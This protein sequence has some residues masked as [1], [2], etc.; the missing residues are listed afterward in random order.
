MR[1][2]LQLL[3]LISISSACLSQSAIVKGK[4][5]D[6][7]EK[8]TLSNAVISL[9]RQ[10]DSTLY[11]FSRSNSNGEFSIPNITPGKYRLLV[12]FPKFADYSDDLEVNKPV[13]DLGTIPL[14]GKAKLLEEVIVRG[15][16][17]IKIKGDTTEF[18]ADSFKVR[19]GATVEDLLKEFPGFQVDSK[20]QITVQGKQVGKVLV[21]GEEFFGDDP[22]MATQNISAKAVDKV[23]VFDTKT[24]QQ[25]LTG[26]S[27]GNE[28]KTVNIKL[29]ESAKK[30]AF[31][32][33]HAASDFD[34]YFDGKALYNNFVGKK[35]VSVYGT[36][37]NLNTGS[38]TYEDRN[39]LGMEEDLEYDEIN[40]Y[41]Y[42]FSN[43]DEFNDY[44]LR[45]LPEA[46]TAGGLFSNKWDYDKHNVNGSYRFNR[47]ATNNIN[48][49]RSQ[50]L[51]PGSSFYSNNLTKSRGLNQQHALNAKYEWKIDSLA[52][53]KFV[54]AGIYKTSDTYTDTYSESLDAKFDTIN[55]RSQTRD[56][57]TER[58]QMD[59]QLTYKQLFRKKNRQMIVTLRHGYTEDDQEG[60]LNAIIGRKNLPDS[61]V[62]Q[63]KL[64]NGNSTTVG[65]KITFSEPLSLK[66][67][68]VVDYSFNNNNSTSHLNSFNKNSNNDK[69]EA[70]DPVF[71]NNFDLGATSNS[72]NLTMRYMGTK[73]RFAFGSGLSSIN[74]RL[75]NL[76][77]GV[78][79]KYNFLNVTPQATFSYTFKAQTSV[80]FSY[81][82][83]TRQ[84][85]INQLQ[86]IRNNEDLMNI[87]VGNPNLKVGFNHSVNASFNSYKVL[88]S[89]YFYI[90]GY[91]SVTENAIATSSTIDTNLKRTY[92]PINVNGNNSWSTQIQ[93]SRGTGDKKFRHNAYTYVNGGRN[94][95]LI[96]G[97]KGYNNYTTYQANY[98]TSYNV[99]D[100]YN[101]Y[102]G[103]QISYNKSKSSLQ[104]SIDNNYFT[105]GG[106]AGGYVMLPGKIEVSSDVNMQLRERV[107]V[108]SQNTDIIMW[109]AN[110]S[111]K[112][113]KDKSGKIF[114]IAN[115]ILDQNKGWNRSI[116]G[117]TITD[118]RFLSV[119][120]YFLLKF[121]WTFN[122]MP[123]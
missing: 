30:G 59:N 82:G 89:R 70:F 33:V 71:S 76:D 55:T 97:N 17:A 12:S 16:Q 122:K 96:N 3:M 121:E 116:N 42:S 47:L 28:S 65:S 79:N 53:L 40:G 2:L 83:T 64:G 103:P 80:G 10:S 87:Y 32:K 18:N 78:K 92:T 57:S 48:S 114:I 119:S 39:K 91:Y 25:Q 84:P 13:I 123:K 34:R 38:L 73:A 54:T 19:D 72:G 99:T 31:G 46:Y 118:S 15:G 61:L 107:G 7:L 120:R 20:G 27:T 95:V 52:S 60:M 106:R 110:I 49:T 85:T 62:D 1:K 113:F 75:H 112:I 56:N 77:N 14:T 111:R 68:I 24:D 102:I 45:G 93:W 69:Y 98:N 5:S 21:D 90:S 86:P 101:F 108:L 117:E 26:I 23:Q 41:Y 6:T 29:K 9:T 94:V 11:K 109:N 36:K 43:S 88:S 51:L 50:T 58:K 44:S 66:W 115:D 4:I 35:K 37:T 74:Y 81:R 63:L 22:T 67:N 100:K 8:K 104:T 105:Y